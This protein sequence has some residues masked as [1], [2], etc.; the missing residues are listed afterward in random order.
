MK[1]T[2]LKPILF[3]L[4]LVSPIFCVG[5]SISVAAESVG[6]YVDDATVT[7]SVKAKL[8]A[9]KAANFTRIG[10]ETSNNVVSLT[11]EVDSKDQK[12]RA[13]KIAK[14]VNGVKR[15]DNKL[16]IKGRG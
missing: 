14:Q 10:V 6:E 13:E 11:G 15:V 3:S 7:A 9:E 8:T 1:S 4:M 16:R 12:E 2:I 5:T